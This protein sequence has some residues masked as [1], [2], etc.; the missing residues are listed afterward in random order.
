MTKTV[1][2]SSA[3]ATGTMF[4]TASRCAESWQTGA[5]RLVRNRPP[6]MPMLPASVPQA[7]TDF[8]KMAFSTSHLVPSPEFNQHL[9]ADPSRPTA[10]LLGYI[11]QV[12]ALV[13]PCRTGA[14]SAN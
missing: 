14:S 3:I 8:Q 10:L 1:S 12:C 9:A 11:R 13:A 5:G 4:A 6:G 2:A 7:T